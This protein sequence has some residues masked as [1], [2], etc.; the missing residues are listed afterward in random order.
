MSQL[1]S[2]EII[3]NLKLN[4]NL[5]MCIATGSSPNATYANL[6]SF[7]KKQPNYFKTLNIVKLDEWGGL[8]MNNPNS[9][10]TY[11]QDIIIKPLNISKSR[12]TSFNSN[13]VSPEKECDR[14]RKELEQKT[15]ID[16]CI[17][18]LGKN[19]HLGFNEPAD[20]LRAQSH[21]VDLSPDSLQHKMIVGELKKPSYGLTL[22]MGDIL[23]SKKII[24]L[25]TGTGKEKIIAELLKRKISTQLPASFLWMHPNVKC[26]IDS[27]SL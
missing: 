12:Y 23:Q 3:S 13:A 25:I 20:S 27:E 21:V 14:I 15:P 18:G 16:I 1:A 5:L 17:L 7:Y 9:C 19:G 8:N 22:G 11:I 2:N 26:Y 24:L 10:E 4:P 6:A